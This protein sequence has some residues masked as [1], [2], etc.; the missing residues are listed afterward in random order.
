MTTII[1]P[2][3][4]QQDIRSWAKKLENNENA[5][6]FKL[7]KSFDIPKTNKKRKI[8]EE[9]IFEKKVKFRKTS[10][11]QYPTYPPIIIRQDMEIRIGRD[12]MKEEKINSDNGGRT[13]N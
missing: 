12:E 3:K 5:K 2:P 8:E 11:F 9:E 7:W 6:N 10:T 4:K 13:N 1:P